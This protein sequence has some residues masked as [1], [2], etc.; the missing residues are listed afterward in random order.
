[1][2]NMHSAPRAKDAPIT[3]PSL[4]QAGSWLA[5]ISPVR[6]AAVAWSGGADSTALLLALH[7][8]G[9][10]PHAWH[11]DHGWH[12]ASATQAEDLREQAAVWGIPFACERLDLAPRSNREAAARAGR[13]AALRHLAAVHG[14][15][16][17]YLAHQAD[18]QAETVCLRLLAGAGVVGLGGMQSQRIWRGI[19]L[20]R[21]LLGVRGKELR[22]ALRT[23]GVAWLEDGSNADLG[24]KRNWIRHCLF[25]RMRAE[26]IEPV[27]LF[28]RLGFQARA[29]ADRLKAGAA[30][31]LYLGEGEVSVDWRHWQGRSRAQRAFDLQRM[32]AALR[33]DG[34]VLG[35][36]HIQLVE[37]W[38]QQGGRG[39]VDLSR[40][41]LVHA[42]G[43]LHLR[44]AGARLRP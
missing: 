34:I 38:L 28:L 2:K 18:D 21:P 32:I 10:A 5:G 14:V 24:F 42:G 35:R 11:I 27:S 12:A 6:K 4:R 44:A 7:T 29:V 19:K 36:R 1:M 17:V 20:R 3:V 40:C 37:R 16:T 25:P 9:F 22:H 26:G 41:R 33:G 30:L 15:D 23:A 31:E 43:R 13:Y 39:G 8:L